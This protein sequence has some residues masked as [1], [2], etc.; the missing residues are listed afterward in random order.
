[1]YQ[2]HSIPLALSTKVRMTNA[3]AIEIMAET[4][5]QSKTRKR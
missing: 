2:N 1:M 4:L 3:I 5:H